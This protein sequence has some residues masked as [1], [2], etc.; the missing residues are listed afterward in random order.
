MAV[1]VTSERLGGRAEV[2]PL[3]PK[4]RSW[5]ALGAPIELMSALSVLRVVVTVALCWSLLVPQLS[6]V[7]E[8]ACVT[9]LAVTASR[10]LLL[11]WLLRARVIAERGSLV[12]TAVL[13]AG[14]VAEVAAPLPPIDRAAALGVAAP[15][16]GFAA[17]FLTTRHIIASVVAVSGATAIAASPGGWHAVAGMSITAGLAIGAFTVAIALLQRSAHR[18]ASVDPDTG[19]TNGH[20]LEQRI[21][22]AGLAPTQV[23][24]VVCLLGL[25]EVREALGH[26]AGTDLF[27]RVVEDL[28]QVVPSGSII[29]RVEG[30]EIVVVQ[31]ISD[32][33]DLL[34]GG[35][36]GGLTRAVATAESLAGVLLGAIAAGR[37]LIGDVEVSLGGRVGLALAPWDGVDLGEQLRRASYSAHVAVVKGQSYRLWDGSRDA[38]TADDLALLGDLRRAAASGQLRLAY[39]PQVA[40]RTGVTVSVEALLRWDHP[41]RGAVPPD[42]FISLAERTGL[43]DRLTEWSLGEALDA[44]VRWRDQGIDLPVSVNLSAKELSRPDLATRVLDMLA[45]RGLPG[46]ALTVEITETA[47]A[48][49]DIVDI[50]TLLE[51]LQIGGVRISIDDFGTGYTSLGVLA[52]LPL[53]ELKVDLGF[54][55]RSATSPKDAAIVQTVRELGHR[56]GLAVVAE[57][58][59]DEECAQRMADYGCDLLQGYHFSRPLDEQRLVEHVQAAGLAGV[60]REDIRTSRVTRAFT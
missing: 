18:R 2:H 31:P 5:M 45:Q 22:Q 8:A 27:R 50:V 58:V 1:H 36:D 9:M 11:L 38:M 33:S 23:I 19:L 20:G 56:M 41:T 14:V 30:D 24:G 53:H 28:G 49:L 26:T 21:T 34:R 43:V 39:Q 35:R 46:A 48:A 37:Y 32:R 29:G 57:G 10:G 15:V 54:V 40:A 25:P 60:G 44:Q 12:A 3:F 47:A 51:P 52:Q 6:G 17:L 59:E 7:G 4:I 42:R 16:C 55:I 13:L